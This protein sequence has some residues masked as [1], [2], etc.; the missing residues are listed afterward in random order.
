VKFNEPAI[1]TKALPKARSEYIKLKPVFVNK[2]HTNKK[3]ITTKM[4]INKKIELIII[5]PVGLK[6]A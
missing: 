5:T 6:C 4:K 2:I 1:E 3:R